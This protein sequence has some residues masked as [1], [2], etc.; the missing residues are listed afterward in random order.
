MLLSQNMVI[1][2]SGNSGHLQCKNKNWIKLFDWW[3]KYEDNNLARNCF[4][5]YT[6]VHVHVSL[7]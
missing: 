3:N 1:L 5:S 7:L 4:R 2:K 6:A